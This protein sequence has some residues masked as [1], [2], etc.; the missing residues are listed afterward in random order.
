MHSRASSLPRITAIKSDHQRRDSLIENPFRELDPIRH[1]SQPPNFIEPHLRS[2]DSFETNP[3]TA[4]EWQN[5]M[6]DKSPTDE[7]HVVSIEISRLDENLPEVSDQPDYTF[8]DLL[9]SPWS[10]VYSANRNSSV[11]E[12]ESQRRRLRA[13]RELASC[14]EYY[15]Q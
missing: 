9:I 2:D 11:S 10:K 14:E 15:F 12:T 5:Q 6:V 3:S 7:L 4:V 8:E 1:R 13:R